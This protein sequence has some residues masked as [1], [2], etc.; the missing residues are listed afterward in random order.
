MRQ[1]N[2]VLTP[3]SCPSNSEEVTVTLDAVGFQPTLTTGEGNPR[4]NNQN[5]TWW[6][7]FSGTPVSRTFRA[8]ATGTYSIWIYSEESGRGE[9][10]LTVE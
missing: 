5:P 8:A 9:Y 6:G 1:V 2:S 7:K 4:T 10:T 3:I